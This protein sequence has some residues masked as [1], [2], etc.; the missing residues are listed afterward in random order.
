MWG[1]PHLRL[2]VPPWPDLGWGIPQTWDGVPS[3]LYLGQSTPLP[4]MGYPP[5]NGEQTDLPKY[6]KKVLL[7]E[8]KRHTARRVESAHYVALCNGGTPS[9]VLG[10]GT[11]SQVGGYPISG[12]GGYPISGR[13]GTPISGLGG[14]PRVPPPPL[15]PD[16]GWGTPTPRPDLGWGTPPPDLRDGV[17]RPT[18]YVRER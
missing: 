3:Y 18:I 10:G 13:G 16:L 7:C 1:L 15:R 12:Q 5:C 4:E 17:P 11:P 9:Q 6:N 14:V 2:G 8:R